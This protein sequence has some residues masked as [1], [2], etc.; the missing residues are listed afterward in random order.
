MCEINKELNINLFHIKMEFMKLIKFL[1][2]YK[3]KKL[4]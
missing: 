3:M 1:D 4:E 2:E